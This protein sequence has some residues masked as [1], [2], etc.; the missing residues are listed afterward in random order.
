MQAGDAVAA[1]EALAAAEAARDAAAAE[2][3][4]SRSSAAEQLAELWRLR[5]EL[6]EATAQVWPRP[7]LLLCDPLL[8]F[9]LI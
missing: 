9:I 7:I 1:R 4:E 6:D 8:L 5:N 2:L 3:A